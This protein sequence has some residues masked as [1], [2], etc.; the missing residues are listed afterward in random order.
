MA[1]S[2]F[3]DLFKLRRKS[4]TKSERRAQTRKLKAMRWIF[5]YAIERQYRVF[6]KKWM[7]DFRDLTTVRVKKLSKWKEELNPKRNDTFAE[8]MFKWN[9]EMLDIQ[10]KSTSRKNLARP[11]LKVAEET[12][13]FNREQFEKFS[14]EAIGINFYDEEPWVDDV[15]EAW[16]VE[17]QSLIKGLSDDYIKKIN[18]AVSDGVMQGKLLKNI[19]KDILKIEGVTKNRATLIARDQIGKLNGKLTQRR[20]QEA[21]L[22]LYEWLTANDERVRGRPGGRYPKARPSHWIMQRRTNLYRWDNQDL[23]STNKGKTWIK[24][25]QSMTK[26]HPGMAIMCR[27]TALP[28]LDELIGEIDTELN[29]A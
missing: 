11:V 23:F 6:I 17:N 18:T 1:K 10:K 21:D 29:A 4:L 5:P 19:R 20:M 9:K 2:S 12:N 22:D 16:Q 14:T 7:K 28:Y 15:L 27:C 24:R 25:Y 3:K 8:D 13:E 26:T